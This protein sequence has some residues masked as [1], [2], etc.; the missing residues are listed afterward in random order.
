MEI[1]IVGL[2]L[3]GFMVYASTRIKRTAAQA[4]EPETVETDD[5]TIEKPAGFLHV[6]NGDPALSFEAYSKET[7][8]DDASRFRAARAA[9]RIYEK[10]TLDYASK[11]VKESSKIVSDTSEVV[12]GQKY[13]GM[14]GSSEE[15][16]VEFRELY[17]LAEK[18]GRVFEFKLSILK[19]AE[20]EVLQRSEA[21]IG[22][23]RLK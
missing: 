5:F 16:E 20:P 21:M 3:V 4:F 14:E 17:K 1:L 13:R 6:L 12:D 22:S 19:T 9:L 15:K 23:F 2:I 18:D 11:A 10:R 8:V 7:G